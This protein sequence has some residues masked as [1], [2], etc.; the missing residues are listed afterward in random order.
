MKA[1]LASLIIKLV[2]VPPNVTIF[3]PFYLSVNRAAMR[4]QFVT[5]YSKKIQQQLGNGKN[6][7]E[8]DVGLTMLHITCTV[9]SRHIH[10]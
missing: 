10:V 2:P 5:N 1:N 3:Q 8:I 6:L 7:E 9:I 4:R